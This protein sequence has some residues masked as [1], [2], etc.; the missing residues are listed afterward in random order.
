MASWFRV[1]GGSRFECGRERMVHIGR[2]AIQVAHLPP[3][4]GVR[5]S[6][7]MQANPWMTQCLVPARLAARPEI[8]EKIDHRDRRQQPGPRQGEPAEGA[9]LLL[10]LINRTGVEG[11]MAAVVWTRRHLIHQEL[12]L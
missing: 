3:G 6:V 12:L 9:Q 4:A 7:E 5:F 1:K 11:V 8:A 10:E 2:Q